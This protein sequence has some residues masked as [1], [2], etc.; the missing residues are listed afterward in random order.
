[1]QWDRGSD[2]HLVVWSI[3]VVSGIGELYV[4]RGVSWRRRAHGEN[5][6]RGGN[7]ND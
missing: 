4:F 2:A 7:Q 3:E 5:E 6:E 1:M